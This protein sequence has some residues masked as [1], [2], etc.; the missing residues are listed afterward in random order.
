MSWASETCTSSEEAIWHC[1][2]SPA[3]LL[4]SSSAP[5]D[6]VVGTQQTLNK[7]FFPLNDSQITSEYVG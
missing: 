6:G 1:D 3:C 2:D 5:P 7:D 4:A